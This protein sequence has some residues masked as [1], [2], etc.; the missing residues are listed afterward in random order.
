MMRSERRVA[1]DI[2]SYHP[3]MKFFWTTNKRNEPVQQGVRNG[4]YP[5]SIDPMS[6]NSAYLRERQA[7]AQ[8]KEQ[9]KKKQAE[10][11]RKEKE[12]LELIYKKTIEDLSNTDYCKLLT[13][14][15]RNKDNGNSFARN[16]T[17]IVSECINKIAKAEVKQ[18][19]YTKEQLSNPIILIIPIEFVLVDNI[20]TV[21]QTISIIDNSKDKCLTGIN[22]EE[23][24]FY[25]DNGNSL[26]ANVNSKLF[27]C[28]DLTISKHKDKQL[29]ITKRVG[30]KTKTIVVKDIAF[31][32]NIKNAICYRLSETKFSP[33]SYI[34]PLLITEEEISLSAE[35]IYKKQLQ[36]K[37]PK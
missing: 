7:E 20:W 16:K 30:N 19:N 29:L 37:Y 4:E 24:V 10:K 14:L 33:K 15:R 5:M 8:R 6:G 18:I 11:E 28:G 3:I 32:K 34:D 35:E 36:N 25:Y 9:E 13:E 17:I 23:G 12:A 21:N 26:L 31:E 1:S 22:I 2:S 27:E